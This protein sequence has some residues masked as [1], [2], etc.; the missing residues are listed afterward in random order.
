MPARSAWEVSDREWRAYFEDEDES[1]APALLRLDP[2]L[3]LHW[4]K[5]EPVDCGAIPGG[6]SR[7]AHRAAVCHPP[8]SGPGEPWPHRILLQL[9]P[10]MAFG[11]GE[12]FTTASCLRTFEALLPG[13]V[14]GPRPRLRNGDP[15]CRCVEAGRP[16]RACAT[17]PDAC[18]VSRETARVNGTPFDVAAGSADVAEERFDCVFAN[19][20]AQTLVELMPVIETQ[21]TPGRRTHRQRHPPASGR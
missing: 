4:E 5:H 2:N 8:L 15:R 11:T 9:V 21:G 18:D 3:S 12:H 17:D 6:P 20:L 7:D 1:I 13:A 10:G 19:I 16:A 14:L